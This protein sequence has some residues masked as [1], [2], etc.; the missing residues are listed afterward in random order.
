[1]LKK[2]LLAAAVAALLAP[3]S[4]ADAFEG[5]FGKSDRYARSMARTRPWHGNY[6]H[7]MTGY[8]IPLVVP[9]TA[10]METRWG[11]GVAQSTMTP[12]YHQ[13]QR[14]YPGG[15]VQGGLQPT[16]LHRSHTDQFGTYYIRG[17]W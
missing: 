13:F 14:D 11:W 15:G 10:N 16:P 3:A 1:M 9:P 2:I 7:T 4:Q 12:I 17:P 6:Y 8:P 5:F